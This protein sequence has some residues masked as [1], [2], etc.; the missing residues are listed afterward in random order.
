MDEYISNAVDD[1][2]TEYW[3]I[4]RDLGAGMKRRK[5]RRHKIG[6]S[7]QMEILIELTRL[8]PGNNPAAL[9]NERKPEEID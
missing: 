7:R 5:T 1:L 8:R 4:I 3:N 2:I 6:H 9:V